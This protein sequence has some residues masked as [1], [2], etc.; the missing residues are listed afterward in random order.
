MRIVIAALALLSLAGCDDGGRN[1]R[2]ATLLKAAR[3]GMN[4]VRGIPGGRTATFTA[5]R[6]VGETTVCGMIDGNDGVGPRAFSAKGDDVVV[7]EPRDPATAAAI[8]RTCTGP[9]TEITS[10]NGTFSDIGVKE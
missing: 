5:V 1:A 6:L 8:E 7:A 9:T 3:E 10:R 2:N 4:A